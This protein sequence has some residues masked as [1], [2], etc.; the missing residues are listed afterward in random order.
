MQNC[1]I[2]HSNTLGILIATFKDG[3]ILGIIGPLI[4]PLIDT[5]INCLKIQMYEDV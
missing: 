1:S 3:R 4:N 5:Y 2:N